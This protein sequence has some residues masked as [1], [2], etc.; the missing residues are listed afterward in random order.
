MKKLKLNRQS[1]RN[2]TGHQLYA[3]RGGGG[4]TTNCPYT[5]NGKC[6][7]SD[8]PW[9]CLTT[10]GTGNTVSQYCTEP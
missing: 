6:Y 5:E 1:I 8:A 4:V 2:L 10:G 9:D 7:P 3:V